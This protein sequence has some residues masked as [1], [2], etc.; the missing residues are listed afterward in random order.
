MIGQLRK[1]T[2]DKLQEIK[3]VHQCKVVSRTLIDSD[4]KSFTIWKT[5]KWKDVDWLIDEV[6][7]ERRE[8]SSLRERVRDLTRANNS[9]LGKFACLPD[10]GA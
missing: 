8:C 1:I 3:D 10:L 5:T 6:E 2:M 4:G 7:R 9:L